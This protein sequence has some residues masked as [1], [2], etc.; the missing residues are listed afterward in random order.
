VYHQQASVVP[1]R[2]IHFYRRITL[3]PI[4]YDQ[5]LNKEV[6]DNDVNMNC[7][8]SGSG[9]TNKGTK[10]GEM[11]TSHVVWRRGKKTN[12]VQLKERLYNWRAL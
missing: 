2:E 6:V 4:C 5:N 3:R 11:V 12:E 1:G 8:D 10:V 7:D 9:G